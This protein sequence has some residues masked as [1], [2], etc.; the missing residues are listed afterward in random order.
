MPQAEN[1]LVQAYKI[2][3]LIEHL[4]QALECIWWCLVIICKL[5]LTLCIELTQL[6]AMDAWAISSRRLRGTGDMKFK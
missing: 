4:N 1:L 6:A 5:N 3:I 2:Q